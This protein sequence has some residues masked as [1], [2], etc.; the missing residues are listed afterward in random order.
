MYV[1]YNAPL[2]QSNVK[3]GL[4]QQTVN[5]FILLFSTGLCKV[6]SHDILKL[7]AEWEYEGVRKVSKY[8][9]LQF[10]VFTLVWFGYS[11]VLRV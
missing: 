5:T 1:I 7:H 2:L 8:C 3:L 6:R 9:N 10:S 4:L 11:I